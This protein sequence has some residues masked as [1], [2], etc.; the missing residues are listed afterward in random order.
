[1]AGR[2]KLREKRPGPLGN[3]FGFHRDARRSRQKQLKKASGLEKAGKVLRVQPHRSRMHGGWRITQRP[4]LA[5]QGFPQL[6]RPPQLHFHREGKAR[7]GMFP[8]PQKPLVRRIQGFLLLPGMALFA[9]ACR[10][11]DPVGLEKGFRRFSA[12]SA[13]GKNLRRPHKPL[14]LFF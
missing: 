5:R 9:F 14:L 4:Q 8:Q 12:Q 11:R 10:R 1:M 3:G 6:I 2:Q 7:K 13:K